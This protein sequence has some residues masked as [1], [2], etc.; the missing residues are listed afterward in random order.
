[1][2]RRKGSGTWVAEG[3]LTYLFL[4]SSFLAISCQ[5]GTFSPR[6]GKKFPR[7]ARAFLRIR[8]VRFASRSDRQSPLISND[9]A[10]DPFTGKNRR[11][12]RAGASWSE[13]SRCSQTCA[14]RRRFMRFQA[15]RLNFYH[16]SRLP[17]MPGY[18]VNRRVIYNRG[19]RSTA[20][21]LK[22]SLKSNGF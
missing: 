6:K 3:I 4:A 16:P 12:E 17:R 5:Q 18:I 10:I 15:V 13:R 21:S 11:T 14:C 9:R 1:M 7:C 20:R 8:S 2:S 22:R 19:A